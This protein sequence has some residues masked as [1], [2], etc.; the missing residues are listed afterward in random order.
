MVLL[1]GLEA[2]IAMHVVN[3]LVAFGLA[4]A[5]GS[6][7]EALSVSEVSWWRILVTVTQHG[8]YLVLVL[9][10]ARRLGVRVVRGASPRFQQRRTDRAV[11]LHGT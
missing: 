8:S 10:A 5:T 2:G 3:N 1:G 7:A 4:I 11:G 9:W 6:V